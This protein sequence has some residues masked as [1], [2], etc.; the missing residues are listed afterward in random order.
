M[1]VGKE[2]LKANNCNSTGKYFNKIRINMKRLRQR[3]VHK[4]KIS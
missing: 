2:A 4:I 3:M 1:F